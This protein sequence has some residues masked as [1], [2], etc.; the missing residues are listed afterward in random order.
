[1]SNYLNKIYY[2]TNEQMQSL[3]TN[4]SINT[5]QGVHNLDS[6]GIYLTDGTTLDNQLIIKAASGNVEGQSMYTY[7]GAA[8]KIINI[9]SPT[10]NDI[11]ITGTANTITISHLDTAGHKHLPSGGGSGKIL[12]WSANGEGAWVDAPDTG[13]RPI[14]V[15]DSA[16][17]AGSSVTTLNLKAGSHI[18][19]TPGSNNGN[20]VISANYSTFGAAGTNHATGLVPDPGSDSGS[21]RFLCEDATWKTVSTSD[22]NVTQTLDSTS[23]DTFPILFSTNNSS[24][25]TASITSTAKRNNSIYIKPSTGTLTATA[26]SGNLNASDISSGTMA[27]TYLAKGSANTALM[28]KGTSTTPAYVSVTPSISVTSGTSSN[29]PKI[30]V[31]V[32][33]VTGT[34][35][36]ELN[37][38]STSIYGATKLSAAA[39]DATVAATAK[40]VY[41]LTTTV[42]SLIATANALVFKGTLSGDASTTYTPAADC[43]WTYMVAAEGLINGEPVEIGDLLICTADD[44]A[45][46]TSSNVAT[47]KT[48]WVIIQ[49]NIDGK[50]Y[51]GSNTFTD[52]HILAADGANGKVKDSPFVVSFTITDNAMSGGSITPTVTNVASL[53]TST[54][55]WSNIYSTQAIIGGL[56]IGGTSTVQYR[57]TSGNALYLNRNA[58]NSVIFQSG[59]TAKVYLDKDNNF[60]PAT[61][62]TQSIG[63]ADYYWANMYATTFNGALAGNA[64]TATQ[65]MVTNTSPTSGTFYYPTY[66]ASTTTGNQS[67]LNSPRLYIYDNSSTGT[68]T[69]LCV[70]SDDHSGGLTIRNAN[71]NYVDIITSAFASNKTLTLPDQTGT[72]ALLTKTDINALINLLDTGS[73]V[74]TGDDYII[75]QYVGGG[76]TT[77][78]YHRRMA[79]NVRVG[80]LTT[81]RSIWGLSFDGTA[82]IS[83]NF[84][85]KNTSS[86]YHYFY[87]KQHGTDNYVAYLMYDSGNAT[88]VTSGRWR[89]AEYSPN[90]TNNTSTTGYKELYYLPTVETGLT[91]DKSYNIL[92]SKD[93]SFSITGN[94]GSATKLKDARSLWGNSFDG[95]ANIGGTLTPDGNRTRDIGSDTAMWNNIHVR[96]IA[97]RHIDAATQS[98]IT[99]GQLHI[100][101][102]SVAPT[103]AIYLYYSADTSSRTKFFEVNSNGAYAP[104]RFGVNG[105]STSYNLYVNG[106]EYV[107]GNMYFSGDGIYHIGTA[108][109]QRIIRIIDAGD[110]YGTGVSI[111][112][113][114]LAIFGSGESTNRMIDNL[115]YVGGSEA[116]VI[117]SDG[118]IWFYPSQ[119]DAYDASSCIQMQQN[120]L[121]IGVNGNTTRESG[122]YVQSGAG[123]IELFSSAATTG[124]RGLWVAAHGTG[125]SKTIISADTNNN[126]T[127]AGGTISGSLSRAGVSKS[128]YQGRDSA[129]IKTTSYSGYDAI[130]SM[131][132]TAGDW[133]LGVYNNNIMY[134]TYIL[135][136]NYSANTNTVTKQFI[137]NP[138][139][140]LTAT[141]FSGNLT[142]NVT[143]NCS[144]SSGSCTGHAASD[145]ALT[146]GTMTGALNFANNTWNTVGDDVKIGDRNAAGTLCIQSSGT[147]MTAIRI[148]KAGDEASYS[149]IRYDGWL[150]LGDAN[151]GTYSGVYF[152][153]SLVRTDGTLRAGTGSGSWTDIT[154]GAVVARIDSGESR[155]EARNGTH[156]VYLYCN[157]DGRSGIYGTR[158]D[159]TAHSL[160]AFANNSS[161]GTFYGNCTGSSGSCTGHASSDLALSGGTMTGNL[162]GSKTN[163]IG[164]T[165]I[166]NHWYKLYLGGSTEGSNAINSANPLIEFSDSDRSQYGQLIY[167]DFDAVRAPDGLTWVGNQ[168]NSWFQAPRVFGA[169]WNDYAEYRE[170]K[171]EIQPGRCVVETGNGDLVLST[172]RLQGGCEIVSDTFGF[173]IGYTKTCKTPTACA[174]RVLAYLYEDNSL[175]K[176]GDPVCSGPNGTVSLMTHEEEIEYPSRIIATVSE[177][178]TYDEWEYG[179]AD[180][181]GVKEK[182]KVDGRIWIRI[183]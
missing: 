143:G 65:V 179:S 9:V 162:L 132:T 101:Y 109:T 51:R 84:T 146:G 52:S 76:T 93:L 33:G 48:K 114:G 171:E 47:I 19:L 173:A 156:R 39:D 161:T 181:F 63:T 72:F 83:G 77:T 154:A 142:G 110:Q 20:V 94:A 79:K 169:V 53:G 37:K 80:G 160:I 183:R 106:T 92:T 73:S 165:A 90:S 36:A 159:G 112:A 6:N 178:P 113:G 140:T 96:G 10:D 127:Y 136:S 55:K 12:G 31:T 151:G 111:G 118:N 40:S 85:M 45:A 42:N 144:G 137:F 61:N 128:W 67:I 95:T 104:T 3:I 2:V 30:N 82:D 57:I 99:D 91:E 98:Y 102:G 18:T 158:T 180:E 166:A 155:L 115:G 126:I 54:Y 139:G 167:T 117:S 133:A 125:S 107:T 69:F 168:A 182:L 81:A 129:I 22:V 16:F 121:M 56:T 177:I 138:D 5:S 8:T 172:E 43:G 28:G 38:A 108:A 130:L 49:N 175:A 135:D 103:K 15:D 131:K 66:T 97:T 86:R 119:N 89:F 141:K 134:F 164:S 24:I 27:L 50:I 70:G 75:T 44:T 105:Q 68:T 176:P 32:L 25:T 71:G 26:F 163:T 17:L 147:S 87:I 64:N 62:N 21:A 145:L 41:D 123:Q 34:T 174:G 88:N 120:K 116:T 150:R 35:A 59:G 4:G 148:M 122:L 13:H 153:S 11:N 124:T 100:G 23:T 78:T 152:G 7:D 1:M 157:S 170:T 29:A 74:L 46:A 60:R 14:Q 58:N 149:T